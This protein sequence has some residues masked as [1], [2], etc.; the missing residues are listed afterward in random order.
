MTSENGISSVSYFAY[1][2]LDNDIVD[3]LG[4]QQNRQSHLG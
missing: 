4:I 2:V 1:H 3:M